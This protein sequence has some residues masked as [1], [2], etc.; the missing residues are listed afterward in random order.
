M[1]H[2]SKE[3]TNTTGTVVTGDDVVLGDEGRGPGIDEV[4]VGG[5]ELVVVGSVLVVD[6]DE[7]VDTDEVVVDDDEVGVGDE[8]VGVGDEEVVVGNE[9]V[10][11][12]EE[13]VVSGCEEVVF[14]GVEDVVLVPALV[15]DTEDAV[16]VSGTVTEDMDVREEVRLV[17]RVGEEL[18]DGGELL[19][20]DGEL[21]VND[22]EL[23]VDDDTLLDTVVETYEDEVSE[24]DED[25][26]TEVSKV[27]GVGD[28]CNVVG[29]RV[30]G[31]DVEYDV[32]DIQ[33]CCRDFERG[34]REDEERM[35]EKRCK[36]TR[37]PRPKMHCR[38]PD[39]A[40]GSAGKDVRKQKDL[41]Q[42]FKEGLQG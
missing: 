41:D 16:V 38:Q 34:V 10:V 4:N 5:S 26:D 25:I 22:G 31:T 21:L 8:E 11:V 37:L 30:P 19:V 18:V 2:I 6:D 9:E 14:I 40:R 42:N 13:D 27:V 28:D 12:A 20:D 1:T 3:H 29:G 15:G 32:K 7:D 23:L 36:R 33:E 39:T 17:V 35:E 24:E